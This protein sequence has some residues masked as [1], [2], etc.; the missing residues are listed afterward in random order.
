VNAQV[1]WVVGKYNKIMH[2]QNAGLLWREQSINQ[3][4]TITLYDVQVNDS[5]QQNET[6]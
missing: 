4:S 3:G 1:G 6:R 2:T 5:P